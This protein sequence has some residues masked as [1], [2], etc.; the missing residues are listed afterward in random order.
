MAAPSSNSFRR[1]IELVVDVESS[2]PDY[3]LIVYPFP[4]IRSPVTF[5]ARGAAQKTSRSHAGISTNCVPHPRI[6]PL[7]VS[8]S[9]KPSN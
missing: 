6:A 8:F 9:P 5:S 7:R 1:V 3:R 4:R 2:Q